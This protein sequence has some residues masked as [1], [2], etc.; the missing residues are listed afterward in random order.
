VLVLG[1]GLGFPVGAPAVFTPNLRVLGVHSSKFLT[2]KQTIRRHII[3][4]YMIQICQDP[5]PQDLVWSQVC[6][7]PG[8][9]FGRSARAAGLTYAMV[10]CSRRP[11]C[12]HLGLRM[13]WFRA[14]ASPRRRKGPEDY[15]MSWGGGKQPCKDSVQALSPP[16]VAPPCKDKVWV[17]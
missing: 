2:K 8:P 1:A 12:G 13:Q 4:L 10:S 7:P 5:P 3:Y 16:P 9:P 14:L 6:L 15:T 11:P 17:W